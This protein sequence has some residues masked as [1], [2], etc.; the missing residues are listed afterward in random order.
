MTLRQIRAYERAESDLHEA[1]RLSAIDGIVELARAISG[2]AGAEGCMELMRS[3]PTKVGHAKYQDS[4][5]L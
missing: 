3:M 5:G 2:L 1:R 4:T